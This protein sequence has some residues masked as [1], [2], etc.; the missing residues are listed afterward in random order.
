MNQLRHPSPQKKPHR[1]GIRNSTDYSPF[2]V[3]LDGRTVS[4]EGYRF[5]FQNQEK[6]DEIKG[7]G[8]TY[9]FGARMHDPRLGRWLSV[10]Q[11]TG[12]Y[13]DKSP[14][15]INNNNPIL[16]VDLDGNDPIILIWASM[17]KDK[18]PDGKTK[19]GHAGIVV[20]NQKLVTRSITLGPH[21]I[22]Y[23]TYVPDGSYTY[24]DL[25]PIRASMTDP[26]AMVKPI[27]NVTELTKIEFPTYNDMMN[28][29]KNKDI[30]GSEGTPPDGILSLDMPG[31]K[32]V[33]LK[34]QLD[35][36][37]HTNK[38]YNAKT[39]NCS[40]N[41][42]K[43]L[44]KIGTPIPMEENQMWLVAYQKNVN[45]IQI[46]DTPNNTYKMLLS[47]KVYPATVMKNA[48]S[49][50]DQDYEDAVVEDNIDAQKRK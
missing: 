6:D 7:K 27:Y 1:V 38:M 45:A 47:Q 9:D 20:M 4:L 5:G 22:T 39:N 46:F 44:R 50:C 12:K 33:E 13:P 48:N 2:G 15:N 42:C 28:Y 35:A 18:S 21:K 19:I 32:E 37:V 31:Y 26:T 34:K 8:N 23:Q 49:R 30:T 10:D 36:Q 29:L 25:W 41:V 16:F 11:H 17:S 14:Y 40:G 43:A 24:Y 3:E